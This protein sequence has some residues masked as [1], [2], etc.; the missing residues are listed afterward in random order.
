MGFSG[1]PQYIPTVATSSVCFRNRKTY[2]DFEKK[3]F[4]I[5]PCRS[6]SFI[7]LS[8]LKG[9]FISANTFL[10]IIV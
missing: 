10:F 6:T 2:W 5:N 9:Y 7:P 3:P 1:V 8:K 4:F